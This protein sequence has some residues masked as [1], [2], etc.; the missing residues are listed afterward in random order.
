MGLY[1]VLVCDAVLVTVSLSVVVFVAVMVAGRVT[2]TIR[3]VV[4]V[5]WMVVVF[6]EKEAPVV[7]ITISG[8]DED[9]SL[10]CVVV[11]RGSGGVKE[12]MVPTAREVE[13]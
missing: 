13:D 8:I 11:W 7:T 12:T 6:S 10:G 1:S 3:V 4:D 5:A 9:E 2:V